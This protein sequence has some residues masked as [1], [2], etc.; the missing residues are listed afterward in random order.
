[1]VELDGLKAM[2]ISLSGLRMA[3]DRLFSLISGK[4]KKFVECML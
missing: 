4:A 2:S 1:M 3:T